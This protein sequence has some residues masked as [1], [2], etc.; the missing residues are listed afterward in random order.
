MPDLSEALAD[1]LNTVYQNSDGQK[2]S[3][4]GWSLGGVYA[5]LLA[6]RFPDRIRQVITLGSPFG[7]SRRSADPLPGVPSSA[8]YSRSDAIVPWQIATQTPTDIAENIEVYA[9]HSGLGFSPTVLYAAADRLAQKEGKWQP[10][11]RTPLREPFFG[12]ANLTPETTQAR[13]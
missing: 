2:I 12:P 10:F 1:R 3:L 7:G 9:S 6:H 5:R 8:I 13:K 11:K 4:V